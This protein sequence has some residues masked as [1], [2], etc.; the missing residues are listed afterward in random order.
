MIWNVG[1]RMKRVRLPVAGGQDIVGAR[2][3]TDALVEAF[4]EMPNVG[5]RCCALR[6]EA[7]DQV[8]DIANTTVSSAIRISWLCSAATRRSWALRSCLVNCRHSPWRAPNASN[9]VAKTHCGVSPARKAMILVPP[10]RANHLTRWSNSA[11][12]S[13]HKA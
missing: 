7:S 9:K 10:R 8:Q 12:G 2:Q 5:C 13:R 11:A 6:D 1:K 4:N 3:R